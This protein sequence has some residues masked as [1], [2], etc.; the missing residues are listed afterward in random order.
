MEV[1]GEATGIYRNG[2]DVDRCGGKGFKGKHG[3]R[4]R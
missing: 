4:G 3:V 2:K 1:G